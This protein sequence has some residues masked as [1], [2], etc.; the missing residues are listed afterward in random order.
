MRTFLIIPLLL[1]LSGFTP[2]Q[3]GSPSASPKELVFFDHDGG[4]DDLL[5]QMLLLTMP[6]KEVIGIAVTPADCY[7]E[8]ALE[9]THKILQLFNRTEIPLGR[10]ELHGVHAFPAEWRAEPEV[11]NAFPEMMKLAETPDPYGYTTATELYIQRLTAV[12]RPVTIVITGPCSTLVNALRKAP[13][14]KANIKQV[15]WMG[16]AFEVPGNVRNYQHNGSAEWN[17][18]WDPARSQYLVESGISLVCIPL[19][20]SNQ[21][22]VSK[23]FLNRLADQSGYALS[24]L[25]A[26]CWATTID[27]IP[28]YVYT[29][30]MWDVL[31]MSYIAIPDAFTLETVKAR[32][33]LRP[34]NEGQ[35]IIDEAGGNRIQY[36]SA[37]N[38]EQFFRYLLEQ[39]QTPIMLDKQPEM[40]NKKREENK[41]NAIAFYR[42]AYEGNPRKAVEL[43]VGDQYIQHNP[44]V[45][46][47]KA[48]FIEY[49]EQMQEEYPD[50]SIEFVRVIAEGNLVALHT[51]QVW[52]GNDEY[53]TMD[54]FRFDENGKI[55]EH[56]DSIQQIPE[57]SANPNTMY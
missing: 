41:K 1:M 42:T 8:P 26:Q 55:V 53:V 16:G 22:P 20:A 35:T 45:K 24:E 38:K 11:V 39:L 36:A 52:P 51:H 37:V 54:F 44:A 2:Q 49:F 43:Y 23:D 31:A 33:G 10:G 29:Y 3:P 13:E 56:W 6:D 48:G 19:D 46:N 14:I 25:A 4:I 40:M 32:T 18:Y 27:T 50:K 57:K 28:G 17:V 34:P 9:S 47:G 30:F 5:S 12:D 7:I 15:I 21:V